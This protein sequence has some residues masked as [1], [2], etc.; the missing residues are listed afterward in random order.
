MKTMKTMN[1]D[2]SRLT[3]SGWKG[4]RCVRK[5]KANFKTNF[6]LLVHVLNNTENMHHV[7]EAVNDGF[8]MDAGFYKFNVTASRSKFI[9]LAKK[10]GYWCECCNRFKPRFKAFL[11]L[12]LENYY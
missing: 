4:G 6:D 9:E 3:M 2:V 8:R 12:A 1:L 5:D 10:Y 11:E 7:T